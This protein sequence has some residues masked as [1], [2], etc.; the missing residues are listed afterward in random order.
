MKTSERH[1]EYQIKK[2]I[3]EREISPSRDLWAEIES[4]TE[5]FSSN[6]R[7]IARWLFMAACFILVFGLGAVFYLDK[8]SAKDVQIAETVAAP[9]SE[10]NLKTEK[11]A[12]ISP[13]EILPT[14]PKEKITDNKNLAEDFKPEKEILAETL[15]PVIK[16]K[17]SEL[18]SEIAKISPEKI[19]A[20]SDSA[21]VQKKKRYVDPSTLLFSVE[22]QDAINQTKDGSNVASIDLNTK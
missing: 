20:K 14:D 11:Q 2:Q 4:Q 8:D 22:H 18:A 1:L 9:S 6:K 3:S 13:K 15:L 17:P 21:K 12:V 19:M 5:N 16:E 10:M 7:K